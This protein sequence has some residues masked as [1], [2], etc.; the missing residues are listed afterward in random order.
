MFLAIRGTTLNV[1]AV[2]SIAALAIIVPRSRADESSPEAVLREQGL[3]RSGPAYIFT[4][5]E[6]LRDRIAEIGRQLASWKE[7]QAGLDRAPRNTQQAQ[8]PARRDCEEA[9]IAR[10]RSAA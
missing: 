4:E 7:E 1:M 8:A 6:D 3:V 2:A 5:E 10:K 9:Q